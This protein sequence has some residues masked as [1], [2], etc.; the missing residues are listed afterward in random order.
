MSDVALPELVDI[1]TPSGPL[2]A[3]WFSAS[4]VMGFPRLPQSER[5]RIPAIIRRLYKTAATHAVEETECLICGEPAP[6][7][8]RNLLAVEMDGGHDL[9]CI[10]AACAASGLFEPMLMFRRACE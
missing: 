3:R 8:G 4:A 1:E 9:G 10:C 5:K 7:E 2:V 6:V